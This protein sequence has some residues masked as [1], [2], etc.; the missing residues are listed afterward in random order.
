[1]AQKHPVLIGRSDI[2]T[3][4]YGICSNSQQMQS[5]SSWAQT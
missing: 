5:P 4:S 2:F 3:I 1:L